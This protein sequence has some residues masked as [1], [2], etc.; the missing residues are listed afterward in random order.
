MWESYTNSEYW[1]IPAVTCA[2]FE[3]YMQILQI[4]RLVLFLWVRMNYKNS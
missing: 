3:M 2:I 1:V 4:Y